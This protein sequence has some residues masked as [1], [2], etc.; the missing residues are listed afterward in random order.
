MDGYF[1]SELQHRHPKG[2]PLSINDKR[3]TWFHSRESQDHFPGTGHALGGC[4]GPSR[5]LPAGWEFRNPP[6]GMKV[7][8][9]LPG[10]K[11]STERLLS[12]LPLSVIKQGRVLEIRAGIRDIF[13]VCNI[14][15]IISM[16]CLHYLD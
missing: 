10:Q 2:V 16:S 14:D 4:K 8:S 11:L 9:D 3:D 1:P 6:N 7:T 15:H 13:K 12:K 5:L